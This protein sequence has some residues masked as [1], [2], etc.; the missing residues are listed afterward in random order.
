M[1][2]PYLLHPTGVFLG[3]FQGRHITLVSGVL[4]LFN[5]I[6][7]KCCHEGSDD[8]KFQE[9]MTPKHHTNLLVSFIDAETKLDHPVNSLGVNGRLLIM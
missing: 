5:L 7:Y 4:H 3:A 9:A 1:C 8:E 2:N 6:I